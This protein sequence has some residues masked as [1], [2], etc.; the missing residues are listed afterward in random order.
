MA[1]AVGGMLGGMTAGAHHS[2]SGV[3]DSSRKATVEGV[4]LE[5]QLINPHPMLLI[6]VKD[7]AG[8][9]QHWRLEMDN[10]G[11]LAAIGVTANTFSP[12]ERVVVSGSLARAAAQYVSPQARPSRGWILA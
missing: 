1:L 10:R 2:I 5:F 4:V 12:G 11:E 7:R 6:D 9:T 3:Y 8:N